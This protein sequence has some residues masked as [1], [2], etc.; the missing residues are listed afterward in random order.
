[1]HKVTVNRKKLLGTLIN[2]KHE[3]IAAYAEAITEY[4]HEL[5]VFLKDQ[6]DKLASRIDEIEECETL[7]IPNI[8]FDKPKPVSYED[9]YIRAIK[10]LE[11]SVDD[12]ITLTPEEFACYVMDQ[13]DWKKQF[14][15]TNTLYSKSKLS[16]K[17]H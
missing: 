12:H 13:W 2:N 16:A 6:L 3:H 5:V 10:M 17:P 7:D 11:M 8:H 4:R 14:V 15:H 1:M 9:H